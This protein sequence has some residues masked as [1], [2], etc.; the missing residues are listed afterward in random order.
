[1]SEH[2][3]RLATTKSSRISAL[4]LLRG[5]F[6]VSIILNHLQWYP[7]GLDWV[8]VQ[9]TLYISAA[10]GFFILSGIILGMVRGRKMI[11]LPFRASAIKVL[12]RGAK[13]Y[14]ISVILMLA[15]TLIGWL[16]IGNPGLKP[17]IRPIDESFIDII[18]GALSLNYLYG[19]ADF[20][21]LYAIF[22]IMSPLALW[23]LRKGKWYFVL[24][25][26]IGLWALFPWALQNTHHSAE[27]LMPL[28]WQL[29]FFGG[30]IIGFHWIDIKDWWDR[31]TKKTKQYILVP[32]LS[33]AVIT[34]T[35]N[36]LISILLLFG[37]GPDSAL[38]LYN[39]LHTTIF[40][41]EALTLPRLAIFALWI[42]LGLFIFTRFEPWIEKW[43]G[44]ILIPFGAN[45]LYVYILHAVIL[46][47]AHLILAPATS[48]NIFINFIGTV[49]VLGLILF[50]VRK[51]F[52]FKVIPR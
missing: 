6:M 36:I 18:I 29:I 41:K 44:W 14:V 12:S 3:K 25:G 32:I 52:L 38:Q 5:F 7:N 24:A 20:L 27:L 8:T 16:F 40:N 37:V 48:T 10:E 42:T 50:A 45:S 26:S 23:L 19:W 47:F 22:L 33:L 43:F 28:S 4:D 39:S 30:L 13:L 46:F 11:N 49:L 17:G 15:F 34:L 51:R 21:R 2:L 9:G 35:I 1:M 31:R